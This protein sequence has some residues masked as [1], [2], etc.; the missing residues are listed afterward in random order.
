MGIRLESVS[1]TYKFFFLLS[2]L[3][4]IQSLEPE[5]D[6]K[7]DLQEGKTSWEHGDAASE[8]LFISVDPSVFQRP[9]Y[10]LFL[11]ILD[12]YERGVS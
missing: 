1:L 7:I 2:P 10:K 9:T 5:V 8:K 4:L 12:N 3:N 6:Y 11:A